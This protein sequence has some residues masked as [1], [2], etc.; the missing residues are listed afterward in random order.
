[1]SVSAVSVRRAQSECGVRKNEETDL[2][3]CI[4]YG[5]ALTEAGS[6]KV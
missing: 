2:S 4:L 5:T 6:Y 1:M 3:N